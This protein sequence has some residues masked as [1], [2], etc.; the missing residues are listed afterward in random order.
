LVQNKLGHLSLSSHFSLV[1][2]LGVR[3]GAYPRMEHL[4]GDEEK[5]SFKMLTTGVDV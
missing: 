2:Y 3:R 5:K 1:E 4:K